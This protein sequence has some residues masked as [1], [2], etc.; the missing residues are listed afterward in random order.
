MK[1]VRVFQF[2]FSSELKKL[3]LNEE[4]ICYPF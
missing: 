3:F 2:N 1:D 4:N